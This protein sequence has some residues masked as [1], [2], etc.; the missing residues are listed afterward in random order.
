MVDLVSVQNKYIY[1]IQYIKTDKMI[2]KI[3]TYITHT[4]YKN[5]KKKHNIYIYNIQYTKTYK[6]YT[7]I[8][9]N[10]QRHTKSIIDNRSFAIKFI[11]QLCRTG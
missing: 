7:C 3:Y 1:N 8:T 9:Y 10:V 11:Q 6:I 2:Y 5:I 4:I